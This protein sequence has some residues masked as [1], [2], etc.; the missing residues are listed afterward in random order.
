VP[1]LASTLS[2]ELQ[3]LVERYEGDT[4]V[5]MIDLR[6]FFL[7]RVTLSGYRFK[8]PIA[9]DNAIF[10]RDV[11]FD[12]TVFEQAA[13]FRGACFEDAQYFTGLDCRSLADFRD[14]SFK[15]GATFEGG[16]YRADLTLT[17]ASSARDLIFHAVR[18][19][20]SLDLTNADLPDLSI[21]NCELGVLQ[22]HDIY[23]LDCYI[24][25]STIR[26]DL[27][28]WRTHFRRLTID[29]V[30]VSDAANFSQVEFRGRC[31]IK[32]STFHGPFSLEGAEVRDRLRISG[33]ALNG[34]F[35]DTVNLR[36]VAVL[37]GG[38]VTLEDVDLSRASFTDSPVESVLFRGVTW[39]RTPAGLQRTRGRRAL[40]DEIGT[41]DLHRLAENY[42]QLVLNHERKR[43]Y[44]AAEDFHIGEME[45]MR[46]SSGAGSKNEITRRVGPWLNSYALYR[47]AS[48]YGT[49]YSRA[50]LVL[51]CMVLLLAIALLLTG[52]DVGNRTVEYNLLPDARH[53]LVAPATLISDF[54]EALVYA[55]TSLTFQ[56][57]ARYS[58]LGL[59]TIVVLGFGRI[60]LAGQ[61]ALFLL[62]LRRRF[63][64]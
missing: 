10:G 53:P 5:Q 49:S 16:T 39:W 4:S 44:E 55:L 25:K 24:F 57:Q 62:A 63:R 47:Y 12:G 50:A 58:P 30:S 2:S 38:S 22:I 59:G 45:M 9:L 40:Q 28:A 48:L 7:A 56:P 20:A 36:R 51:V 17:N 18:I 33:S 61:S 64:R 32:R 60:L 31:E 15:Q 42:R 26:D 3:A 54:R 41:P 14:C 19:D 35:E 23:D 6:G 11:T 21:F 43:D 52:F 13:S 46:R 29:E 34:L 8:K 27:R 37:A 1:D